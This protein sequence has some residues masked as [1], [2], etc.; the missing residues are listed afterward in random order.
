MRDEMEEMPPSVVEARLTGWTEQEI[1]ETKGLDPKEVNGM[2]QTAIADF[3]K[4]NTIECSA[5]TALQLMK[6]ELI[7]RTCGVK[8]KDRRIRA[9]REQCALLARRDMRVL[10]AVPEQVLLNEPAEIPERPAQPGDELSPEE[11]F[12]RG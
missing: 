11:I 9:I 6:L 5:M 1:A 3:L 7:Q 2:I 10:G 4:T 12:N 8:D